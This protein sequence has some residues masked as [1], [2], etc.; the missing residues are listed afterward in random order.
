MS[1]PLSSALSR[2]ENRPHKEDWNMGLRFPE[3]TPSGGDKVVMGRSIKQVF[4]S[5]WESVFW[6]FQA[7][8]SEFPAVHTAK[9]QWRKRYEPGRENRSSRW[10]ER[11]RKVSETRRFRE[12]WTD[13]FLYCEE[14]KRKLRGNVWMVAQRTLNVRRGDCTYSVSCWKL[15][16]N[17]GKGN[18]FPE[19]IL[20]EET[21]FS[22]MT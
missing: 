13:W 10:K 8:S 20:T 2:E 11:S 1:S 21:G 4:R 6:K 3:I 19:G 22:L 7:R 15:V 18:M 5:T 12:Y 9:V 17:F 16:G 14:R